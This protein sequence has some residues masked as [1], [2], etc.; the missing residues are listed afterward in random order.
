M[1]DNYLRLALQPAANEKYKTPGDTA[2]EA[3]NFTCI[4]GWSIIPERIM[5]TAVQ[6]LY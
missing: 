2:K 4:G 6:T 5:R 3:K 1:N